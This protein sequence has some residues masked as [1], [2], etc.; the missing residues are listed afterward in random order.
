[1]NKERLLNLTVYMLPSTN[2]NHLAPNFVTMCTDITA[3]MCS[4]MDLIRPEES[5]LSALELEK[6]LYFIVMY[7]LA[8]V[9][10]YFNQQQT[11]KKKYMTTD[12]R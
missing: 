4:I 1:M 12:L 6:V 8:S 7:I 10:M 3:R 5:E 9:D 11:W 2:I